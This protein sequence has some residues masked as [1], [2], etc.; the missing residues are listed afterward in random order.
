[1]SFIHI[2]KLQEGGGGDIT[3]EVKVEQEHVE[4][5]AHLGRIVISVVS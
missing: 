3:A 4:F 2:V 5:R 1:M